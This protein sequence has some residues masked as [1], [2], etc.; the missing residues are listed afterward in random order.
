MTRALLGALACLAAAIAWGGEATPLFSEHAPLSGALHYTDYEGTATLHV[1]GHTYDVT[2]EKRGKSRLKRCRFPPLRLNFQR[3]Q[4]TGTV[5]EG[6]NKLKLVTHCSNSDERKG[7]LAAEFLI[8]RLYNQLTDDSFRVRW[9]DI[10][11]VKN[12]R[13]TTHGAFFIEHKRSLAARLDAQLLETA[14]V[15]REDL[16]PVAAARIALF[17]YMVGNTDYSLERGPADECC[18]NVVPLE[19]ADKV[20][21]VPYDFDSTG[22]VDPDY[23]TPVAQLGI[24]SVRQRLYRGYCMHDDQLSTVK[25]RFITQTPALSALL[26][27]VHQLPERKRKKVGRYLGSFYDDLPGLEV[28]CR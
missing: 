11:Y 17:A 18:H 23:A 12:G 22:V 7:N 8:Y 4:L 3:S 5:F 25:A 2:L 26:D 6:Q 16:D 14:Q 28:R 10:D 19:R 27:S 1:S 20:L 13:T 21:P 24:R 15:A 9:I